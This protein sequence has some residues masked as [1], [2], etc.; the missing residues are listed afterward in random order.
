[1]TKILEFLAELIIKNS[2]KITFFWLISLIASIL[3]LYLSPVPFF[4]DELEG[5]KNTEAYKVEQIVKNEFKVSQESSLGLVIEGKDTDEELKKMLLSSFSEFSDVVDVKGN[6]KHKNQLYFIRFKPE[7][8]VR[9]AQSISGKVREKISTWTKKTGIKT[10]LTGD[11][12]FFYDTTN[13]SKKDS[14]KNEII[15]MFLS[16]F[17]LIRTFGGLLSAFLPIIAGATTLIYLNTII[18]ILGLQNNTVSMILNSLI[19]LAL[20]I[21]YSLFVISRFKEELN[22]SKNPEEALK[23]ALVNS[24]KTVFFSSLIMIFSVSVLYLPDV[25]SSKIVVKNIIN[26]VAV[27]CLVA[28]IILPSLAYWGRNILDK[29]K[30]ISDYIKRNDK[31]IFWRKFA[32]HIT[33]YPKLYFLLS[34]F[35]LGIVSYPILYMKIWEPLQTMA[36]KNSESRLGYETLEK[37]GWG[38][39]LLPIIISI[40]SDE[41]IFS[42]KNISTIYDITEYIKKNQKVSSILSLTSINNDMNKIDYQN[43]YATAFSTGSLVFNQQVG[44]LVNQNSDSKSSII[45]VYVKNLMDITEIHKIVEYCREYKSNDKNIEVLVGG[46]VA[47]ARDF[48]TELYRPVKEMLFIVFGGI[49]IILF[50]YMK[51]PILPIKA[52]FMNFLPIITAFGTLTAVFQFGFFSNVLGTSIN[53]G[54]SAMVPVVLFCILFGL[55]MDYEVLILSRITENYQKTGNVKESV[56]EG[57]S[58]SSSVITGAGLILLSV[59]IPGIFSSSAIVQELCIGISSAILIDTTVIRLVLVPSFMMIMGKYNWWKFKF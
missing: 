20:A 21:D 56:I 40:K 58:K 3:F 50:I 41:L 47:R 44:Y 9:T 43:F 48:S 54:I 15:A 33:D 22:N 10:Y 30:F 42:N 59:F 14:A 13:S 19:G 24:G 49:F 6:S 51:T 53:D 52:A 1:M 12:A 25:S 45:Y 28:L 5:A 38:G 37:D 16:F 17:I 29:P 34:I 31:Y 23:E 57:I 46:V 18:R 55:S 39:E 4:E 35:I 27:S 8:P 32:T 36:P 26:I 7:I 2:K 11:S